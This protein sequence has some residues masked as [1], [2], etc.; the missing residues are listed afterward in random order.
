MPQAAC[1]R[2]KDMSRQEG[3]E[4]KQG[5]KDEKEEKQRK[6]DS[7]LVEVQWHFRTL[8]HTY[9]GRWWP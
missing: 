4:G 6:R 7:K 9:R 3:V 2:W 1:T 8:A 5:E